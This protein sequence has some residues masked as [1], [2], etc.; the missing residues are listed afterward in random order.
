MPTFRLASSMIS[1]QAK[2]AEKAAGYSS[3]QLVYARIILLCTHSRTRA[4]GDI[5]E[6]PPWCTTHCERTI[7]NC[8]E[9]DESL[10]EQALRCLTSDAWGDS[11]TKERDS[12]AR[13]L[14]CFISRSKDAIGCVSK[15]RCARSIC[16][17]ARAVCQCTLKTLISLQDL[18]TS[19]PQS[20]S[21]PVFLQLNLA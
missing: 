21:V 5:D 15:I 14:V 10:S 4:W 2:I 3:P 12:I 8:R 6:T 20:F 18:C 1:L 7:V 19:S 13:L 11:T 9:V 16:A 17:P